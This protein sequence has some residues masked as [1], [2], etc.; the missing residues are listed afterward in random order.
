MSDLFESMQEHHAERLAPIIAAGFANKFSETKQD[1]YV[2]IH[3]RKTNGEVFYVGKGHGN[4]AFD[5]KNGRNR[6]WKNIVRKHGLCVEFIQCG[7]RELYA[8]ELEKTLIE[9]YGRIDN[10]TGILCNMTDG[11]DGASG[12]IRSEETRAKVSAVH[13]GKTISA[14]TKAKIGNANRGKAPSAEHRAKISAAISGENHPMFG[15]L[16]DKNPLFGKRLTK[17]HKE[18]ISKAMSG[19]NHPFFGKSLS[20]EHRAN[21]SGIKNP[22]F[23]KTGDANHTSKSVICIETGVRYGS[24]KEAARIAGIYRSGICKSANGKCGSAGGYTWKFG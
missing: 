5:T 7:L 6:H 12:C 19:E 16:G 21:L 13:K 17:E 2:Y 22:F 3:R 9:M 4:R 23:G 20:D 1:F 15:M 24:V 8:F 14:E 18:K 10:G 11:G